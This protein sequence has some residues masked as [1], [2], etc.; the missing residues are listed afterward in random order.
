MF[1]RWRSRKHISAVPTSYLTHMAGLP[2]TGHANFCRTSCWRLA[3][4]SRRTAHHNCGFA[5]TPRARGNAVDHQLVNYIGKVVMITAASS[6]IG[7][8]TAL[9]LARQTAEICIGDVS[10][11]AGETLELIKE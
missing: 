8:T 2:T 9:A 11:G 5:P 4:G 1:Q 10:A 6:G 7:R 3:P